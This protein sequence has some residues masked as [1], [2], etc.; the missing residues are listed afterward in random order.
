[1]AVRPELPL[2]DDE[3]DC[4]ALVEPDDVEDGCED[5]ERLPV[6]EGVGDVSRVYPLPF[7]AWAVAPPTPATTLPYRMITGGRYPEPP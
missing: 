6:L 2:L 7:T 5:G 3:P 4:A 1:M